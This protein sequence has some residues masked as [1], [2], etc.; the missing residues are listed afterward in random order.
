LRTTTTRGSGRFVGQNIGIE[1]IGLREAMKIPEELRA[2]YEIMLRRLQVE[3][4]AMA[5]SVVPGGANGTLGKQVHARI[6]RG[7]GTSQRLLIGTVGSEFARALDRGFTSKPQSARALRFE[8]GQELVFTKRVRVAGRHFYA[9]WLAG[10]PPI[11][12]AVYAS[13]FYNI[14]DLY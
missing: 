10:T 1:I 7:G 2:T 14:R 11:V 12:E 3:V 8:E 4:E 6:V 13:S 5:K 9:K